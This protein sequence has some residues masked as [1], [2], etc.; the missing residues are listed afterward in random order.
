MCDLSLVYASTD[1]SG[2]S[3]PADEA[4]QWDACYPVEQRVGEIE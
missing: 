3:V 1:Q 2:V 4:Q